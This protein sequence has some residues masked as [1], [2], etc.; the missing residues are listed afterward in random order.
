MDKEIINKLLA[1]YRSGELSE[2][3]LSDFERSRLEQELLAEYYQQMELSGTAELSGEEEI[4]LK[5]TMFHNILERIRNDQPV[6]A[7]PISP[8]VIQIK[9]RRYIIRFAAAAA[10]LLVAGTAYWFIKSN[11]PAPELSIA[12]KTKNDVAPGGNKAMLT[13]ANGSKIV[14]DSAANDTIL[15]EGSA[16]VAN[17]SGRLAYNATKALVPEV[18]Y[19]TLTTPR[20]GQY[21]LT[22]PDGTKVWLNAAS[23]IK[24]PIAFTGKDR[25]VEMTGEAY[26]EVAHNAKQPFKVKTKNQLIQDIGTEFNVNTYVDEVAEKTTLIQGVIEVSATAG[27]STAIPMRLS[28][29]EQ[30]MVEAGSETGGIR[31]N[32]NP[33]LDETIA[34]K[35][36]FFHFESADLKTILR[37]FARWYDIEV[38]YEG[39]TPTDKYFSI[40]KRNSTLSQV[41]NALQAGGVRFKIEGRTLTV[42]SK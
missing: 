34:W 3:K 39:Q 21:Q 25:T 22:L 6:E 15:N 7:N 9:P 4:E 40:V 14:L 32:K 37:Q 42:E 13:L 23:S 27:T 12:Q 33:D 38:V 41:L 2:G 19:N 30:A 11:K 28:R 8:K 16:I 5:E 36:G 20:G 10:I 35:E 31:L 29:G 24:Y 17:A 1:S 26:F 18:L